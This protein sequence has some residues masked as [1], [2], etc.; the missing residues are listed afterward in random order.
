MANSSPDKK[1]FFFIFPLLILASIFIGY[2]PMLEKLAMRWNSGD[3]N[4]CFLV[5]PVFLYLCWE[6]KNDFR[7]GEFCWSSWGIVPALFSVLVITIGELG[8]VETLLYVGIWG[9]FTSLFITLYGLRRSWLLFFPLLV[10]LFI[11]PMPPY[12]NQV[13]T[14]K[15]KMTASSLSVELMRWVGITVLQTGNILDLGISK[16]QVVDACS[17]LRYIVSMVLLALLIGHFYVGGLWRK[18]F[19]LLLVY[20]LSIFTNAV[21]I[22]LGALLT[23][24][25]FPQFNEGPYHDAQGVIA[26]LV[27]GVILFLCGWLLQKVGTIRPPKNLRNNGCR[28]APL[29]AALLITIFY[30]AL[31]GGSGW[32]L[33]NISGNMIIPQRTSFASFPMEIAGWKGSRNYLSQ[34]ILDS[35]WADDYVNATFSKDGVPNTIYLLI[36]YYEYQG[37]SHTAHAPQSCLLGGGFE[38]VRS[39]TRKLLVSADKDIDIGLLHLRKDDMQMLAS[40]FFYERGRVITS[41][42]ENKLYLMWDAFRLHRTDGALVR[43]EMTVPPGQNIAQAEKMLIDFIAGGLWPLLPV[44]IPN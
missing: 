10:L 26:F 31:F 36:P 5:V 18:I 4:Y 42:W 40:Y 25:G 38:L 37:T 3:N 28:T 44:Y 33:Q 8:S 41:P 34:E 2:W 43:V 17:G 35:L 6:K 24:N 7:F 1:N 29:S 11:V 20:P 15:M 9:C 14:F 30:V 27:A 19:L 21:R 32:A 22:F 13:L 39:S 12:I 16:M 23:I